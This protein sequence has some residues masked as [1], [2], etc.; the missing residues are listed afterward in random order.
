MQFRQDTAAK[1]PSR[2]NPFPLRRTKALNR[3]CPDLTP[4]QSQNSSRLLVNALRR[5]CATVGRFLTVGIFN[6][7]A[8]LILFSILFYLAG[9]HLLVANIAAFMAAIALG[10]VL[11]KAWTFGDK[12]RGSQA[13]L[14]GA[15][16][17]AVGAI[18]LGIAT[19]AIWLAAK[20]LPALV[21]KIV[22][23]LCAFAWTYLA[24][25]LLVFRRA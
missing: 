14:K 24:A 8:D 19:G 11:N 15:A 9:W 1:G 20:L 16:F 6:G 10:F 3:H 12:S 22:A 13:I 4:V 21:A 17:G 5:E 7:L 18:S 2:P 23:D 25:R